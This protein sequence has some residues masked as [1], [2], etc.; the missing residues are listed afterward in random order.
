MFL[1]K[2]FKVRYRKEGRNKREEEGNTK[3]GYDYQL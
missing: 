1:G 3:D 2:I